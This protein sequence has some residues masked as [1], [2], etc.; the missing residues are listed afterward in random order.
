RPAGPR[1]PRRLLLHE[2]IHMGLALDPRLHRRHRRCRWLGR[3]AWPDRPAR[4]PAV[5]RAHGLD[6]RLRPDLRLSGRRLRSRARPALVPRALRHRG[7][8]VGGTALSRRDR[9][10]VRRPR[11]SARARRRVLARLGGR[12]RA[13]HLRALAGDAAR[14]VARRRGVLQRE[15]LHRGHR[16]GRRDRGSALVARQQSAPADTA[17]TSERIRTMF[18]RIARRYDLMNGLM[19]GGRHHAW[20][21]ITA[22]ALGAAPRGPVLDLATGTGDLALAV[23]RLRPADTVVGADF[24]AAMLREAAAKLRRP[25]A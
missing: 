9:A 2:A 18:T 22:E 19:T 21:R 20:R 12:G 24:A 5:A 13:A 3:R 14:S 4:V 15:R 17:G 11:P 8:A 7:R 25:R 16:A 10:H 6:R 1:V 23:A